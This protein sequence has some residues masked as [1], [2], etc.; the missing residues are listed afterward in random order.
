MTQSITASCPIW[1]EAVTTKITFCRNDK[2]VKII[3]PNVTM[4]PARNEIHG[5]PIVFDMSPI[6]S[7][8]S[9]MPQGVLGTVDVRAY[10]PH[11]N[12]STACFL[13]MKGEVGYYGTT[14]CVHIKDSNYPK[15]K[16]FFC[17]QDTNVT[18][19]DVGVLKSTLT[20]TLP[21]KAPAVAE[22]PYLI[23][24]QGKMQDIQLLSDV[25]EIG[26]IK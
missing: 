3:F 26:P 1:E 19:L 6:I 11:D 10:W 15:M 14:F 5:F 18:W 20:F 2:E 8:L 25:I 12:A 17:C 7:E 4:T 21:D 22:N 13:K 24:Y 9:P 16:A 23:N